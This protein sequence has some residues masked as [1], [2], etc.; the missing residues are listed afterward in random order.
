MCDNLRA[1]CDGIV[2]YCVLAAGSTGGGDFVADSGRL[3]SVQSRDI[4]LSAAGGRE[5]GDDVYLYRSLCPDK[6]DRPGLRTL[7]SVV[8]H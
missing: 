5:K 7:V 8:L 6:C 1:F 2:H 4:Y 3:P